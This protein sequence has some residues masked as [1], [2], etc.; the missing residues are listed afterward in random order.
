MS[1]C[2]HLIVGR[3]SLSQTLIPSLLAGLSGSLPVTS[4]LKMSQMCSRRTAV[5]SLSPETSLRHFSLATQ[6]IISV[7]LIRVSLTVSAAIKF[8][9]QRAA[10]RIGV[11]GL[12]AAFLGLSKLLFISEAL[13][14]LSQDKRNSPMPWQECDV[15]EVFGLAGGFITL[16]LRAILLFALQLWRS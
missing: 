5:L 12:L 1:H 4:Q 16:D 3:G 7:S 15:E 8:C 11:L 9:T 2:K 6:A 14:P 10:L 13:Q